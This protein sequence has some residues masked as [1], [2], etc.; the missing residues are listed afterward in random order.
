MGYNP[1]D[2]LGSDKRKG[3]TAKAKSIAS[4]VVTEHKLK[5]KIREI[6]RNKLNA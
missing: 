5:E 1:F 2:F 3:V 6:I 4:D